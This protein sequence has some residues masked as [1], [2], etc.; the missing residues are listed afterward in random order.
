MVNLGRLWK[1]EGPGITFGYRFYPT[2][3]KPVHM[4]MTVLEKLI[5]TDGD[6]VFP[7][8]GDTTYSVLLFG[9]DCV[10]FEGMWLQRE[11]VDPQT[12]ETLLL[13]VGGEH[14]VFLRGSTD[15]PPSQD[16]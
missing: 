13:E 2:G 12:V 7:E 16:H 14:N 4:E 5:Q 1:V 9:P 10:K 8:K 3:T 15:G 11:E 6:A